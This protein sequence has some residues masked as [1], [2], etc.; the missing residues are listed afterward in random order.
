MAADAGQPFDLAAGPLFRAG[1][2]RLGPDDHVLALCMHHIVSDEWSLGILAARAVDRST[3]PCPHG[4][5]RPNPLPPLPVQ[6]ADFAVWQ[7][8]WLDG[9]VLDAQLDYWRDAARRRCRSLDLPTD[10]P[11]PAVR[12]R[13]AAPR[14]DFAVRP[15]RRTALRR[16]RRRRGRDAVHDAASRLRPCCSA[17]T[18]ARTT[19]CVGTPVANRN[20]AEIEGLIGFFVN[21]LVLRT[22]LA[23][24]PTFAELLGPG[25][26]TALAPTPTRTCRS[27]SSSTS[28]TSE[29][30]RSR[31]HPVR[32]WFNYFDQP[33]TPSR[34]VPALGVGAIDRQ[35][36]P[37]AD[38]R[39][40]GDG[41]A[42]CHRVQHGPV[43]AGDDRAADRQ[44]RKLL[45]AVAADPGL[46][47]SALARTR[48]DERGLAACHRRQRGTACRR[49]VHELVAASTRRPT[50][51]GLIGGISV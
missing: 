10:R 31:T 40:G 7:R 22:D 9:D 26:A 23:G 12:V 45:E 30:D 33:A 21:T 2:V 3:T 46:P 41:V 27:S 29:R 28:C 6:Y 48:R 8:H 36:R 32:D 11:R 14:L 50:R 15:G 34:P 49:A 25:P 13:R 20:R 44:L 38:L 35:V 42:G 43:R 51:R 16:S 39:R 24:D 19:S 18:P 1:L 47:L 4:G 5:R 37:A 17:A